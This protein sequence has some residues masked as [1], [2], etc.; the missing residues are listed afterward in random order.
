MVKPTKRCR[1]ADVIHT[2]FHGKLCQRGISWRPAEILG[3]WVV[4]TKN[5]GYIYIGLIYPAIKLW[6]SIVFCMFTRGYGK[7]PNRYW[8]VV[9]LPLW[10]SILNSLVSSIIL[11]GG[12]NIPNIWR[13][14]QPCLITRGYIPYTGWWYTYPSEKYEFVSWD[15]DIPNIWKNKKCSKPTSIYIHIYIYMYVS[16][17]IYI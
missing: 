12:M 1:V 5:I 11:V 14:F 13:I 15:D 16:I 4:A 10:T 8:L 17:Y 9:D 7:T 2:K 3:D 6:F